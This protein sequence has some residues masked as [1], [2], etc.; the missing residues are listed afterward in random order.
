[1]LYDSTMVEA[2]KLAVGNCEVQGIISKEV[3]LESIIWL[4]EK[5]EQEKNLAFLKKALCHIL[6]YLELGFSYEDGVE[7]FHIVLNYLDLD[8]DTVFPK[9]AWKYRRVSL[10]KCNIRSMLGRWNPYLHSMKISEVVSDVYNKVLEHKT[11]KYLYYCGKIIRQNE[12]GTLW[13]Q[14][15]WL[16]IRPEESFLYDVNKN[17]YYIFEQG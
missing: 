15:Y 11:G 16:Y 7:E 5:Y 1:M 8:E 14:T 2:I 13:E 12:S 4:R 3:L 9:P 17:K 10:T 6:A